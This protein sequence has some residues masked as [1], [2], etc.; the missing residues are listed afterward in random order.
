MLTDQ[1]HN[2][3]HQTRRSAKLIHIVSLVT[4]IFGS[5]SDSLP[6]GE[7]GQNVRP[8][9]DAVDAWR[10][11]GW[12]GTIPLPEKAK[13]PPPTGWTGRNA[14]FPTDEAVDAWRREAKYRRGNIGLR[15]GWPVLVDGTEYEVCGIDVDD[16][17]SGGKI[18]YGGKQLKQ[19]ETELGP[20]PATWIS[21]ARSDG[22]SGIRYVL[23]P[24]GLAFVGQAD[25][26]IEVVQRN[27]RYAVTWPSVHPDGGT[28]HLYPPGVAPDGVNFRDEIPDVTTLAFLPDSWLDHLTNGKTPDSEMEIDQVATLDELDVWA[29][30]QFHTG[31]EASACKFMRE[32]VTKWCDEIAREATSHDKIRGAHWQLVSLAAEGHTGWDWAIG[33]V[34]TC[35]TSDVIARDKREAGELRREV[36]RSR[37]NAFRK[38]KA[39]VDQ[40]TKSGARYTPDYCLCDPRN[41]EFVSTTIVFNDSEGHVADVIPIRGTTEAP[42]ER[43]ARNAPLDLRQLR[44]EPPQPISWLLPDVLAHDSYVSLSAAPGTGKSLITRAIA[45]EASL[46]RSAFDPAH[47]I[48]PARVIYFDAEN[49]Q[50]WWRCGLDSMGAP[51]DLPNLAVLCYP[52]IGGLD[53]PKGAKEFHGLIQSTADGHLGGVVDLIVLDT[54]SRFIDGGENDADTWSQFYRLAIQPLRDQLVAVLRLDHLGKDADKGPRGSS[55]KLSDVDAD[56]RMTAARAGS[57]DLTLTLGKRRRQHFSETLN[58]RRLDGPLRHELFTVAGQFIMQTSTGETVITDPEVKAL[59]DDLARLN[60]DIKL[61]REK[62]KDAYKAAKGNINARDTVWSNA[63][64]VRKNLAEPESDSND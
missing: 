31:D 33:A 14:G 30:E 28:Y 26:D 8:F 64:K 42:A 48:D 6:P 60:V 32:T 24:T 4:P 25:A 2:V 51:L 57:D 40:A 37:T 16:Y 59:V 41:Y 3:P 11:R 38:V 36:W 61:G 46:G 58:I 50:D 63:I 35:W 1:P 47:E 19:L 62:A 15:L 45:V 5:E 12:L 9:I 21:S 44:T 34:E 52:D 54:V 55:H 29:D 39:K 18:K 22:T 17:V 23:V 10:D 27:H 20:L 53:T 56:F 49:G 13:N 7:G 43:P